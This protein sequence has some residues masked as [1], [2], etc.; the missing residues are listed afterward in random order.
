MTTDTQLSFEIVPPEQRHLV[1]LALRLRQCDR[2][3]LA[4]VTDRD[5]LTSLLFS[6]MISDPCWV[7][8]VDGR[9]AA[10]GGVA[11]KIDEEDMGIPWFMATDDIEEKQVRHW[12]AQNSRRFLDDIL[13]NYSRLENYINAENET[14]KTW[15]QWLGFEIG[16]AEPLGRKGELMS[17]IRM[18]RNV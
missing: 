5:P 16:P 15:L 10:I 18:E 11:P 9:P 3:E 13:S 8:T 12:L 17:R 7:L 6:S 4:A 14:T 1:S 2:N